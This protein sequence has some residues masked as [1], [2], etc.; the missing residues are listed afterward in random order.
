MAMQSHSTVL[1]DLLAPTPLDVFLKR[2]WD[3]A[4]LL[5]RGDRPGQLDGAARWARLFSEDALDELLSEGGLSAPGL[6]LH[7]SGGGV[8]AGAMSIHRLPWGTGAV[9]GFARPERVF[10]LLAEGCSLSLDAADRLWGPLGALCADLRG[11]LSA[12]LHCRVLR[13][14]VAD[15]PGEAVYDVG[16]QF[17]L[18]VGGARRWQVSGPH[19]ERPLRLEQCPPEGVEAGE[20][21]LEVRLEAGDLLY[22]PRGFVV[23]QAG[24]SDTASLEVVVSV[25]PYTWHDLAL[26][27][28]RRLD[29]ND[30]G[31]AIRPDTRK[32]VG[33]SDTQ[34]DWLDEQV[35]NALLEHDVDAALA[36]LGGPARASLP[37]SAGLSRSEDG[38]ETDR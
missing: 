19:I 18:Q 4:P 26:A 30:G 23:Q 1:A 20:P 32:A 37:L 8:P 15:K 11:V 35:E 31:A 16:H 29:D 28:A 5:V 2:H 22:V 24:V 25:V 12:E 21:L 17:V 38:V 3:R 27:V 13:A 7:R 10:D 9:A 34:V 14:P 33:L 36:S 6:R